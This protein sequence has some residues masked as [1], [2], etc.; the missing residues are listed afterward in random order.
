MSDKTVFLVINVETGK[1]VEKPG[2]EDL[3]DDEHP[4]YAKYLFWVIDDMGGLYI[5]NS[6]TGYVYEPMMGKYR[7][8]FYQGK[9]AMQKK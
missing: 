7:V 4:F 3:P 5:V 9:G 8:E 2:R 1:V 6:K